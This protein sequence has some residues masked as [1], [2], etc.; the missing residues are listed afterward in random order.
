MALVTLA[1]S[2]YKGPRA[3]QMREGITD[4]IHPSIGILAGCVFAKALTCVYY[5]PVIDPYVQKHEDV[6]VS[7]YIDDI[8]VATQ[9]SSEDR[10]ADRMLE[11][12]EDLR[13]LITNDLKCAIAV[14]KAA[15]V[16]STSTVAKAIRDRMGIIAGKSTTHAANWGVDFASGG[17]RGRGKWLLRS[18]RLAK[19]IKGR[20]KLPL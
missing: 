11:A 3:L 8:T 13:G 9:D 10:V 5:L 20:R 6:K 15:V 17:R 4:A 16:A 19:I 14:S 18:R 1:L 12:T 7:I 2:A